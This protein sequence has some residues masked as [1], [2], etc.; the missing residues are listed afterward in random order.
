MDPP[1]LDEPTHKATQAW[2][3]EHLQEHAKAPYPSLP[4]DPQSQ[5]IRLFR[6]H[7]GQDRL[8]GSLVVRSMERYQDRQHGQDPTDNGIMDTQRES[9]NETSQSDFEALSYTWGESLH[10]EYVEVQDQIQI[11]ITDNLARALRRLR[12]PSEPRHLWIDAICIDQKNLGERSRQVAYMGEIYKRASRVIIWLGDLP[13][14]LSLPSRAFFAVILRLPDIVRSRHL[15]VAVLQQ[16]RRHF[17]QA[18]EGTLRSS[19]PRW[20]ERV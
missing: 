1:S 16:C 18:L 4:L 17:K 19:H 10:N 13:D 8:R 7:G 2:L 3:L 14:D 20:H 6:L 11:P 12:Y 15:H 5:E 9:R